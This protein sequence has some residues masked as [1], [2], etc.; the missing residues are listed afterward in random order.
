MIATDPTPQQ[1]IITV[2]L[3]T[4]AQGRR[5]DI[6]SLTAPPHPFGSPDLRILRAWVEA[7]MAHPGD[8]VAVMSAVET[9]VRQA[10]VGASQRTLGQYYYRVPP[11]LRPL[12]G[13]RDGAGLKRLLGDWGKGGF[14]S[15]VAGLSERESEAY[16]YR[17]RGWSPSS[18]ACELTP[19]RQRHDRRL[20]LSVQT[21]YNYTHQARVKV[22]R[23]FGLPPVLE[24][25]EADFDA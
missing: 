12:L 14:E 16:W 17:I 22:L 25:G 11:A 18:I 2:K 5:Q 24:D 9:A 1:R 21:V 15:G 3:G 7:E 4:F 13:Q 6:T 20:W 19:A 8:L 23:A 10:G